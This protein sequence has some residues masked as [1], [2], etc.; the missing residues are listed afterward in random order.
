VLQKYPIIAQAMDH[1]AHAQIRNRGTFGG[2]MAHADPAGQLPGVAVALNAR[3]H[4]RSKNAE[5][6]VTADDFF[7]GP[8]TTVI[9]PQEMLVE[10]AIP[11]CRLSP[12]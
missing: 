8:F 4:I 2:A 5:R 11:P 1:I 3:F 7:M 6:W 12:G 10:V 9:E